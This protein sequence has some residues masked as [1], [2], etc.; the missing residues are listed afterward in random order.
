MDE[1][2]DG[3][4]RPVRVFRDEAAARLAYEGDAD[5]RQPRMKK[6]TVGSR[7]CPAETASPRSAS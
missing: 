4:L 2:R 6:L 1:F 3:L 5:R 7:R